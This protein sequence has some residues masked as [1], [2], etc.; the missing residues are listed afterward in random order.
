MDVNV[1]TSAWP[2]WHWED[3]ISICCSLECK[4]Y[5]CQQEQALE[6][7]AFV[8]GHIIIPFWWYLRKMLLWKSNSVE[9][10]ANNVRYFPFS[11]LC[12]VSPDLISCALIGCCSSLTSSS[13][14]KQ[15]RNV[16]HAPY[17]VRHWDISAKLTNLVFEMLTLGD[18]CL[19]IKLSLP[20]VFGIC[21]WL[22]T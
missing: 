7:T 13:P 19:P 11:E 17:S 1:Q 4:L 16:N 18:W 15:P 20:Q 12:V 2:V 6:Y 5:I 3:G 9:L 14:A 10:S 8:L 22:P 21:L